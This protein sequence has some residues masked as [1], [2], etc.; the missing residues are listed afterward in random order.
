MYS[1]IDIS[2]I[3][4]LQIYISDKICYHFCMC[5][6]IIW[7]CSSFAS[8]KDHNVSCLCGSV[9]NLWVR[10]GPGTVCHS[11]AMEWL[12]GLLEI[13]HCLSFYEQLLC[14]Q[15]QRC[16]ASGTRCGATAPC[17]AVS[18]CG[19][20]GFG[21]AE[22]IQWRLLSVLLQVPLSTKGTFAVR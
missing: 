21:V 4:L 10:Y 6:C 11:V 1:D 17:R 15:H 13:G 12:T 9:G 2:Q 18:S 7:W 5:L 22:R 19:L 16:V 8:E 20:P 14:W 3:M